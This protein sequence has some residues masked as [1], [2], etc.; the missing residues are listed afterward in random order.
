MTT[1]KRLIAG[2][3]EIHNPITTATLQVL[4]DMMET[5]LKGFPN[6]RRRLLFCLNDPGYRK[7]K[8]RFIANNWPTA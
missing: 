4:I 7:E 3:H 5:R 2:Q 1:R 6:D 8:L